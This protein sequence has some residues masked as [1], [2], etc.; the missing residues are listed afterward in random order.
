V[1]SEARLLRRQIITPLLDE[2]LRKTEHLPL[3]ADRTVLPEFQ[4]L[5]RAV[6]LCGL[7]KERPI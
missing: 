6:L 7:D 3:D 4:A 5:H 2:L 1:I